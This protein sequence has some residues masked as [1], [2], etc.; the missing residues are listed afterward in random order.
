MSSHIWKLFTK[1]EGNGDRSK[2]NTCNKEYASRGGTTS[3]LINHLKANH[4]ELHQQYLAETKSKSNPPKKRPGELA[5]NQPSMKQK[6]IEDCIPE[7]ENALNDAITDTIVDFLA[8]SGIAFRVVGLDSFH[9]LMRIANR[10]I[11]LKHPV[12]YSRIVK[13]RAEE[14]RKDILDIISTVKTDLSCISFTTDMWTSRA[15]DPFMSLTMHFIDKNWQLHR[16]TPYVAPFPARHTGSNIALGLDAMVE[17]LGLSGQQWELFSVND[18]AANVKL[19]IR[20]SQHLKQYLCDIHTLEL[21][22]K[23]TFKN[24][25]G[26]KAVLKKT[27]AIGT[28]T[29]TSTVA[30]TELKREAAKEKIK[31]R[32]IANPPTTRWTGKHENLKSILYLKKPL[33]SLAASNESWV[34]HSLTA[35]DWKLVE[36]AVVLLQP[37]RDTIKAWEGEKDSTMHRVIERIYTMHCII[38]EFLGD[39]SNSRHGVGFGRELKRQIEQ[40]FPQKG[41]NNKWRRIGNYLAPQFKGIHLEEEN[42]FFST[43][44][45]IE[46]EVEKLSNLEPVE[47]EEHVEHLDAEESLP[48]SP[49]SK[50]RQKMQARQQRMRTQ[51]HQDQLS[52]VKR[53][54]LRY[55]SF[56]L[57]EKD[58]DVLSW[59]KGH[60]KVMPLLSKI[61][62]K[63]LTILCS[64]AKSERVF[65]TGGNFVTSKRNSLA[66]KKV[67][68]LIIIKENKTKVDEFKET[69]GYNLVRSEADPFTKISVETVIA[70]LEEE[71]NDDLEDEEGSAIFGQQNDQEVFFYVDALDDS[72][73]EDDEIEEEDVEDIT[74]VLL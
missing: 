17:E 24:V 5:A 29:H 58:L 39:P 26:M 38:D 27:K 15:G 46:V 23:G 55:E 74:D 33:Q 14:I 64:S 73:F 66:P 34:E 32:K 31:F 43:K 9:K 53:E 35:A 52:A 61:A 11:K 21:A 41:T 8:D 16:W 63:A 30:T 69:G 10:R 72:D 3:A 7:S 22:V 65:S 4:K 71:E 20:L 59:W 56:S 49:T 18:N 42:K 68:D 13:V 62:K 54:M 48:L 40:R 2:C 37:V 44:D 25:H 36:G 12:T 1:L 57:P 28:F 51:L 47:A 50:L 60:E 6:K 67:E 19:G 70:N 45:E